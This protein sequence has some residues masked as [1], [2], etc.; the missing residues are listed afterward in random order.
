MARCLRS[1]VGWTLANIASEVFGWR[2]RKQYVRL[3]DEDL[4]RS[5][6]ETLHA[7][8]QK[9]SVPQPAGLERTGNFDNRHPLYGNSMRFK[10]LS[11]K[12]VREDVAWK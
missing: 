5:P 3:R 11:L 7:T 12:Q 6:Q 8:L 2:H 1:A 9:V 4:A 10:P